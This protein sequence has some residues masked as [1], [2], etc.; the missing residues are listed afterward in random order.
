MVPLISATVKGRPMLKASNEKELKPWRKAVHNAALLTLTQQ[1][2]ARR[3]LLDGPLAVRFVF[4]FDRPKSVT[5]T[6]PCVR[7]D[8]DKLARACADSLSTARIWADDGRVVD[9]A[10]RKVYVGHDPEALPQPGVRI[11]VWTI[12][13]TAQPTLDGDMP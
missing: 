10:I 12:S 1:P 2:S 4:T 5:R 3:P 6:L 9:W 8:G 11:A 7:P 13:E